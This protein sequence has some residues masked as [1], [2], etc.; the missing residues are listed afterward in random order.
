MSV[1]RFKASRGSGK[2][3]SLSFYTREFL[4]LQHI[5]LLELPGSRE[6]AEICRSQIAFFSLHLRKFVLLT[7]CGKQQ[8]PED[9]SDGEPPSAPAA[10]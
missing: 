9:V 8:E 4:N 1:M 3:S 6:R 5:L 7:N 2:W 10:H